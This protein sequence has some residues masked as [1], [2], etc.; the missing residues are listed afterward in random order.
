MHNIRLSK[1]ASEKLNGLLDYLEEEWSISVALDFE[2]FFGEK[3]VQVAAFPESCP[4]SKL[5]KTY[6]FVS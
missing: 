4:K 3:L 5:L 6:T 1:L 2:N